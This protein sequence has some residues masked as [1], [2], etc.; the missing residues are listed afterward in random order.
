MNRGR[1]I[2]STGIA[3]VAAVSL[4]VTVEYGFA[5]FPGS[6]GKI[7]FESNASGNYEIYVVDP[8]GS[9]LTK[10]TNDPAIDRSPAW[11]PDGTKI[12]FQSRRNGNFDLF[13]MFADGTGLTQITNDPADEK[14][15]A[16]SPDGSRI[17]YAR[18]DGATG[19]NALWIVGADGSN[20]QAIDYDRGNDDQPAW[21]PKGDALAFRRTY[22]GLGS[23]VWKVAVAGQTFSA[24]AINLTDLRE[25]LNAAPSWSP[26]GAAIVF[27]S[28]RVAGSFRLFV[29][30][31]DGANP[32]EWSGTVDGDSEPAWSPDGTAV[33]FSRQYGTG[34]REI[35]SVAAD[36]LDL[37]QLTE[38]GPLNLQHT[39]ADWQ[40]I[41]E[42]PP[43]PDNT[44]PTAEAGNGGEIP[45]AGAEGASVTLDGSASSDPDSTP[46]T[47]DDIVSFAWFDAYGTPG[48]VALG[49]GESLDV[50]LA[51]GVH[52]ITLVVTD[53]AGASAIDTVVW[54]VVD[55]DPP[56]I[57]VRLSPAVLWPATHRMVRVHADVEVKGGRC[58]PA[59]GFVLASVV[60]SEP[61]DA[62]GG[63]DGNT[64]HDIQG[65]EAG[66]PDLDFLVRA[67]R[68]GSGNGR[69]Y[70]ATY[71][72][73]G[74]GADGTT[75]V[76][77]V[78]VPHD[79]GELAEARGLKASRRRR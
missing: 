3:T 26:D 62:P 5:G 38:S 69:V 73:V 35:Q 68:A 9:D 79:A 22:D 44:P 23:D 43:P 53:A 66:T 59:P 29:I 46:G 31:A 7:A 47:N 51:A 77:T 28:D 55:P 30:D 39:G 72:I 40:A 52:T 64:S 4:V 37:R 10:L 19:A 11:S 2:R 41:V 65:V 78:R 6:N 71:A 49:T 76:A 67:E 74:G 15:P 56:S 1:T 70:T 33:A 14:Q 12:A 36:G 20:P 34:A 27:Q 54:T 45:C 61:D 57:A 50:V 63:G 60:S 32:R 58:N 17:A 24:S 48:Q 16:W 8:D 18:L 13:V 21:S 42:P 75:A 25:S